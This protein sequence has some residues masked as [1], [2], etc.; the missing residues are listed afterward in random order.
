MIEITLANGFQV[1]VSMAHETKDWFRVSIRVGENSAVSSEAAT[2]LVMSRL[3][4][5]TQEMTP[6]SVVCE[7]KD[8]LTRFNT[9]VENLCGSDFC[10]PG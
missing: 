4:M 9:E 5:P 6:T 10:E 1:R 3:G 7:G 8:A 2:E